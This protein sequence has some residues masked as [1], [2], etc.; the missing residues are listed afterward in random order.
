MPRAF[1]AARAGEFAN[2]RRAVVTLNP[3]DVAL[4]NLNT[5]SFAFEDLRIH[6]S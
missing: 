4:C 1:D 6:R 3:S 2:H 5:Q